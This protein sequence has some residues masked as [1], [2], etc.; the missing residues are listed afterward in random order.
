[1]RRNHVWGHCY[2]YFLSF[3]LSLYLKTLCL[4]KTQI[5]FNNN[6]TLFFSP[7]WF[8]EVNWFLVWGC[9]LTSARAF[10]LL[11]SNSSCCLRLRELLCLLQIGNFSSWFLGSVLMWICLIMH[12]PWLSFSCVCLSQFFAF[13]FYF[14][15]RIFVLS[16]CPL[17]YYAFSLIFLFMILA[18]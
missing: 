12:K 8:Y 4:F 10:F 14:S 6:S 9:T 3:F 16:I 2:S 18:H 1:M 5:K 11:L 15:L 7:R 17:W 13:Y